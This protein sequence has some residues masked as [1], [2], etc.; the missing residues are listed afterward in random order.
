MSKEKNKKIQRVRHDWEKLK[1]IM[2]ALAKLG[3]DT[4]YM[5]AKALNIPY[6]T[7]KQ[8]FY[9]NKDFYDEFKLAKK[10][11]ATFILAKAIKQ[12]EHGNWNAIQYFLDR[13]LKD[14]DKELG[15]LIDA[16]DNNIKIEFKL[17][18]SE[19][20]PEPEND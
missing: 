16:D 12:V 3:F 17:L 7:L 8:F 20:K 15:G 10:G 19:E 14:L 5:I 18:D 4:P 11:F 13:V 2:L 9:N 6:S 1:P